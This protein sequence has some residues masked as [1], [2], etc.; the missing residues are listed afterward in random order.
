MK[1]NLYSALLIILL[2]ATSAG[3]QLPNF[4]WAEG[5]NSV[6]GEGII[7]GGLRTD[8]SGNIYSVG[9][10]AGPS[11]TLGAFTLT[12]ASYNNGNNYGDMFISKQDASGNFLWA[13]TPIG[14]DSISSTLPV[15]FNVDGSG[16][17][18]LGI[19]FSAGRATCALVFGNDTIFPL[20]NGVFPGPGGYKTIISFDS[21]GNYLW[22]KVI[23]R[24]SAV[25]TNFNTRG[26]VAD[27]AGNFIVSGAWGVSDSVPIIFDAVNL[28]K[29]YSASVADI[30][31]IKFDPAGNVLYAITVAGNGMDVFGSLSADNNNNVYLTCGYS[32]DTLH[33]GNSYVVNSLGGGAAFPQDFAYLKLD[34]NGNPVWIK[35]IPVGGAPGNGGLVTFP[36][37]ANSSGELY[38]ASMF[39]GTFSFGPTTV[40]PS[41][42]ILK[43]DANGDPDWAEIIGDTAR[44]GALS[45]IRIDDAGNPCL[46]GIFSDD[47]IRLNNQTYYNTAPGTATYDA[48]FMKTTAARSPYQVFTFGSD[49]A[50]GIKI[51]T[52][53][54]SRIILAGAYKG[55]SITFGNTTLTNAD[56][57]N[58]DIYWTAF[59]ALTNIGAPA[60]ANHVDFYPNPASEIITVTREN[61]SREEMKLTVFNILGEVEI[62]KTFGEDAAINL[63]VRQLI[64]GVYSIVIEGTKGISCSKFIKQ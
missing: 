31:V 56:F 51:A 35:T 1:R 54:N 50:D 62:E 34:A 24:N 59:D 25:G 27:N 37:A 16:N 15:A 21:N 6:G 26:V 38:I 8:N 47:S 28:S 20:I 4:T 30:W 14:L 10:F 2:A 9:S 39:K 17:M 19:D 40:T 57:P 60:F 55:Q 45:E 44:A 64:P 18:V 53:N 33:V 58:N 29:P 42:F 22:H 5:S 23:Y 32:S 41:L 43:T 52:G 13:I 36:G 49:G 12:H 3:A 11:L 46:V 48:F 63:N 7:F 61:Q